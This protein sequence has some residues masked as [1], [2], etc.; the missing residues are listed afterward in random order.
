MLSVTKSIDT[1]HVSNIISKTNWLEMV[2]LAQADYKEPDS[3]IICQAI[4]WRNQIHIY[5]LTTGPLLLVPA[6][7][8]QI[9]TQDNPITEEDH[10]TIQTATP[11]FFGIPLISAAATRVTTIDTQA[12]NY[13]QPNLLAFW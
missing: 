7:E 12:V 6:H 4:S 8:D 11:H 9:A 1:I 2:Y 13:C 10:Q 3:D 5:L